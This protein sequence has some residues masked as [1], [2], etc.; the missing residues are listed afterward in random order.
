MPTYVT[1]THRR[2]VYAPYTCE[3]CGHTDHGAVFVESSSTSQTN[4]VDGLDGS[5]DLAHGQAHGGAE[6][7]GDEQIGLAPCPACGQRDELAVRNFRR[8]ANGPLGGGAAFAVLALAGIA[9]IA[10]EGGEVELAIVFIGVMLGIPAVVLLAMG[11]FR[12]LRKLPGANV[13]FWSRDQRPWAHMGQGP[14][15]KERAYFT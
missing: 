8:K 12:R 15:R 9:Y 7:H 5:R 3:H 11:L 10:Y 14:G 6:D 1:A 13:I 2:Y 4:I